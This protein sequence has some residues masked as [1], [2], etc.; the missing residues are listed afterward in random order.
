MN[1]RHTNFRNYKPKVGLNLTMNT[2]DLYLFYVLISG[3]RF[4]W[5]EGEDTGD[6]AKERLG[7]AK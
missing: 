5:K 2:G 1:R 4:A 3:R 7:Q 6:L